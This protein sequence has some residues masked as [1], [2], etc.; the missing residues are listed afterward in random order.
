MKKTDEKTRKLTKAEQK[1]QEKFE[2]KKAE[3]EEQGYEM[4]EHTLGITYANIMAFVVALPL[5]IPVIVLYVLFDGGYII[6]KGDMA[7]FLIFDIVL[8]VVHEAV[9]GVTWACFAKNHLKSIEFGIMPE[10]CTPYC[11]C[12][13][14]LKRR[15]YII[16]SL[17][18]L[19]TVGFIPSAFAV[20]TGKFWLLLVGVVMI[21]G[22]GGDIIITHRML[23]YKPE[24]DEIVYYDHPT[25][26]GFITF[27][28]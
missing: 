10:M 22:A 21:V 17:M 24:K 18:P 27:E 5:I 25:K 2:I 28:R 11:T 1:R 8:I 9:H 20:A 12:S 14:P 15:Q 19:F 23:K 13:E 7:L 16:G 4:K 6:E 26:C 3:L